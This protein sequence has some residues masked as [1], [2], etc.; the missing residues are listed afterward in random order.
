ML[1]RVFLLNLTFCYNINIFMP[2]MMLL[3]FFLLYLTE[4]RVFLLICCCF[5]FFI[6][7]CTFYDRIK[8]LQSMI[9]SF[10]LRVFAM[11][12]FA[13]SEI[14]LFDF[15]YFFCCICLNS[16]YIFLNIW[17]FKRSFSI[18]YLWYILMI[19]DSC[20]IGFGIFTS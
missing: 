14:I 5:L 13:S 8:F 17:F 12:P 4:S 11:P 18:N 1:P 2:S 6:L 15:I 3:S 9:Y 10:L 16:I 7:N 19:R 20:I